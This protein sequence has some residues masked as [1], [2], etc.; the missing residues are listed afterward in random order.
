MLRR[1]VLKLAGLTGM[2]LGLN[3]QQPS[4]AQ[5][6]PD[7]PILVMI[8]LLGGNDALNMVVPVDQHSVYKS[9]RPQL[10]WPLS[11]LLILDNTVGLAPPMEPLY[12]YFNSG[13]LALLVGIGVPDATTSLFAHDNQRTVWCT[14][15]IGGEEQQPTQNDPGWLGTYIANYAN[16]AVNDPLYSFQGSD[17]I[18]QLLRQT[19]VFPAG[20]VRDLDFYQ[21]QVGG[22]TPT[23]QALRQQI[24]QQIISRDRSTFR[25]SV[26]YAAQWLRG[27]QAVSE[28]FDAALA[29]GTDVSYPDTDLGRQLA[30]VA[31]LIASGAPTPVHYCEFF[32]F[33]TH[34][35]QNDTHPALLADLAQSIDAFYTDI[36]NRGLHN[37]V[38]L[39]T[40]SEFGRRPAENSAL[41]TDHGLAG[42]SLVLG[43]NVRGGVYGAYANLSRVIQNIDVQPFKDNMTTT[44]GM[45]FLSVYATILERHLG[46]DPA[47][48]PTLLPAI[49]PGYQLLNF[50]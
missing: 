48:T 49:A 47:I 8:Y 32:D 14:G 46:L 45:D 23:E 17:D 5:T 43:G 33:D 6:D 41:G 34:A 44:P 22:R 13:E 19:G 20:A 24:F 16:V 7:G 35:N 10:H 2:S 50:L 36:K 15:R 26:E 37:R 9:V 1:H 3:W 25:P 31:A 40:Y 12:K 30:D 4:L 29:I 28:V 42:T 27:E 39:I 21:I 11:D 38:V 18:P